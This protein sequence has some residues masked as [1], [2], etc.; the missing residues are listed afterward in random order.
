MWGP[1]HLVVALL[2]DRPGGPRDLQS[3][4]ASSGG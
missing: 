1:V 2:P 3:F 4:R